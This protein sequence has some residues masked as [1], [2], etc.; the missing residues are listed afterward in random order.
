[1]A[2]LTTCQAESVIYTISLDVIGE[3]TIT[4]TEFDGVKVY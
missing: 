2:R 1:V 3:A 4:T